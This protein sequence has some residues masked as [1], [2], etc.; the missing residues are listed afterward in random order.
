MATA[1]GSGAAIPRDRRSHWSGSSAA[2]ASAS[3]RTVAQ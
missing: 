1:N 2:T 3:T